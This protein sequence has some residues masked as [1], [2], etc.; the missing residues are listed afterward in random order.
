M[1]S[2]AEKEASRARSTNDLPGPA[3][4]IK[5]RQQLAGLHAEARRQGRQGGG[6]HPPA[7][8][9]PR[10]PRYLGARDPLYLSYHSRPARR[11][12]RDLL[13]ESGSLFVQIGAENIHLVR[14]VLDEVFGSENFCGLIPVS[15]RAISEPSVVGTPV[16]NYLLW[17]AKRLEAVKVRKLFKEKSPG[18]DG[19]TVYTQ[20]ELADGTRRRLTAEEL[21][22]SSTLSPGAR[23]FSTGGLDNNGV[24][25]SG[26]FE[27]VFEGRRF[28]E[29]PGK[30]WQTTRSGMERLALARRLAISGS[31]LRYVRFVEDYPVVPLVDLWNDT[32]TGSFTDAK[33][34]AVQTNTKVVGR[35]S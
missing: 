28:R 11:L 21:A 9:G 8:A 34:Y 33:I 7:R 16:C 6:R 30:H 2:L 10:L 25:D 13:T 26:S 22:D 12:A 19:A 24:T 5:F 31:T 15:P 35:A 32:I 23:I 14:A 4:R 18:D 3:V 17:Y 1:S 27:V 29:G 20:V